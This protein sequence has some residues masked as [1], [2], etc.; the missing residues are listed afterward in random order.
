M[1]REPGK[2]PLGIGR[3]LERVAAGVAGLRELAA[4]PR[5][6]EDDPRVYDFRIRWGVLRSGRLKRLEHYHLAG[7]LTQDQERRY[8]DLKRELRAEI[9]TAERL[10]VARPGIPLED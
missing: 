1:D 9:P 3:D 4:D 2:G 8:R 7:E 10:G 6:A 5:K